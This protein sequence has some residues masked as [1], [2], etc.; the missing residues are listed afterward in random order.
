MQKVNILQPAIHYD[1]IRNRLTHDSMRL[2]Y[3]SLIRYHRQS[4]RLSFMIS[5]LVVASSIW[6]DR[7]IRGKKS[8]ITTISNHRSISIWRRFIN[9]FLIAVSLHHRRISTGQGILSGNRTNRRSMRRVQVCVLGLA[10]PPQID[11]TLESSAAKLASE[12]LVTCMFSRVRDQVAALR[13]R[14]A[15]YLTFMRFL[16][17]NRKK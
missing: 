12:W 16:A 1:A 17:C 11:L 13:E 6:P 5:F 10:M 3:R 4:W 8:L 7:L 2:I 15:A 14:F 9:H